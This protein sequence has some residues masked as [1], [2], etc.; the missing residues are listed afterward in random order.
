MHADTH[1]RTQELKHTHADT[2]TRTHEH[3]CMQ[4]H[5]YTHVYTHTRGVTK[6]PNSE[7]NQKET[8]STEDLCCYDCNTFM[9]TNWQY[10]EAERN[11]CHN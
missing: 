11:N 7:A 5:T 9:V 3:K 10:H 4:T 8:R 1:T 6:V 2:H